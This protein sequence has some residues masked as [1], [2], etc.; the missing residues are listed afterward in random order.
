MKTVLLYLVEFTTDTT[1]IVFY[2]SSK[3]LSFEQFYLMLYFKYISF[4]IYEDIK[5][6]SN[7]YADL[8]I[9]VNVRSFKHT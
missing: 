6:L 9:I 1:C 3:S 5:V 2:V 7:F 4:S 8:Q